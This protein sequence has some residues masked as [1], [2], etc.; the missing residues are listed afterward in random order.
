MH[1]AQHI[2]HTLYTQEPYTQAH[3]NV[4][5]GYKY[6]ANRNKQYGLPKKKRYKN[7]YCIQFMNLI[8]WN[9]YDQIQLSS[10]SS[11]NSCTW[12]FRDFVYIFCNVLVESIFFFN[13]ILVECRLETV[14]AL[15]Y[16]C[17]LIYNLLESQRQKKNDQNDTHTT[18]QTNQTSDAVIRN[19]KYWWDDYNRKLLGPHDCITNDIL[20]SI[21]D[22]LMQFIFY[23]YCVDCVVWI[24]DGL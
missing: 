24:D 18:W 2:I 21:T 14:F 4:T 16:G 20:K 19:L 3:N 10:S 22:V 7:Y 17:V 12:I 13:N 11:I 15:Y 6:T 1:I 23:Y 9:W 8:K 5:H